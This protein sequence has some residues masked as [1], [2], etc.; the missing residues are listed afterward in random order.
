M[1]YTRHVPNSSTTASFWRFALI[2]IHRSDVLSFNIVIGNGLSMNIWS[3]WSIS[4]NQPSLIGSQGHHKL[5]VYRLYYYFKKLFRC[6]SS[7]FNL[8]FFTHPESQ[9]LL[10]LKL[11]PTTVTITAYLSRLETHKQSFPW[12]HTNDRHYYGLLV[13]S[14]DP[15]AVLPSKADLRCTWHNGSVTPSSTHAVSRLWSPN[16]EDASPAEQTHISKHDFR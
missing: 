8:V 10:S 1:L 11:T 2:S 9:I 12:N 6:L 7:V 14:W 3:T 13:P 5:W 4:I 15:Q 16:T